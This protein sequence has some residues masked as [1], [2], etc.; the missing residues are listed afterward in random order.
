MAPLATTLLDTR[1]L[2][3]FTLGKRRTNDSS[4]TVSDNRSAAAPYLSDPNP[5]GASDV[6]SGR[7]SA[8]VGLFRANTAPDVDFPETDSGTGDRAQM[9]ESQIT[10][11][12]IGRCV[13]AAQVSPEVLAERLGVPATRVREQLREQLL[14]QARRRGRPRL[15]ERA[16]DDNPLIRASTPTSRDCP[17]PVLEWLV[18]D[19]AS[20]V[21]AAVA[22]HEFCP[23]D[24][25]RRLAGD[26]VVS[27]R[28]AAAC[29]V[30]C[31][32]EMGL[33][34]HEAVKAGMQI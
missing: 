20:L 26:S 15:A 6:T 34:H 8:A 24:L 29:N 17:R 30:R 18:R 10:S 16:L 33:E 32:R 21:R 9:S 31:P 27:V 12:A 22:S 19:S 11:R 4:S 7:R 3:F 23:P 14:T 5:T 1:V 13:R 2:H 28:D 25:L